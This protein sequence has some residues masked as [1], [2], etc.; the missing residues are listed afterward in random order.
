MSF[1]RAHNQYLDPP[2]EPPVCEECFEPL[3]KDITDEYV[4]E[5]KYCPLKHE[6]AAREMA[7]DLIGARETIKSLAAKLRRLEALPANV[8][9]ECGDEYSGA[10]GSCSVGHERG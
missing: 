4:C 8:C 7:E 3:T 10:C 2:D 9:P 6:G 1:E 5:N